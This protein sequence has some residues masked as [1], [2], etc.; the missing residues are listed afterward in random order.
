MQ[1]SG[2]DQGE[3]PG[4]SGGPLQAQVRHPRPGVQAL[5]AVQPLCVN[6]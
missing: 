1:G 3:A 2:A 4:G 5:P 6:C